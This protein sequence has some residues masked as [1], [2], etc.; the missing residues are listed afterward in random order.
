MTKYTATI[1]TIMGDYQGTA[2]TKP[3]ALKKAMAEAADVLHLLMHPRASFEI[4]LKSE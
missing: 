4:S 3:A 1:H 2:T